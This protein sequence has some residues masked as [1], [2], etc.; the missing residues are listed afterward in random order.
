MR[1][2]VCGSDDFED[3]RLVKCVLDG[4]YRND[5]AERPML[6]TRGTIGAEELAVDWALDLQLRCNLPLSMDV[7]TSMWRLCDVTTG[8]EG[9]DWVFL[10]DVVDEVVAFINKPLEKCSDTHD[11]VRKAK[12]AGI[13]VRIVW[14]Y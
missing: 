12:R 9:S 4:L 10:P 3:A 8:S 14:S 7:A 5:P 1:W 6:I 2:L 11:L 13:S